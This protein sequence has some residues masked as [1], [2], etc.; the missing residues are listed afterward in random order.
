MTEPCRSAS[1]TGPRGVTI[2]FTMSTMRPRKSTGVRNL[3]RISTTEDSRMVSR[4]T[5]PKKIRL[6]AMEGTS[7]ARGTTSIS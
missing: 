1:V 5:T 4:K 2:P 6:P 3:P 7:P